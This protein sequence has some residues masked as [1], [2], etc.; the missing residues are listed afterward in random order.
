MAILK[1]YHDNKSHT[2]YESPELFRMDPEKYTPAG[3]F[4]NT[5]EPLLLITELP[6][7]CTVVARNAA[8]DRCFS[9]TKFATT[10]QQSERLPDEAPER[11]LL[12]DL[13][14]TSSRVTR[15]TTD[16]WRTFAITKIPQE[17]GIYLRYEDV[18]KEMCRDQQIEVFSRV[19]RHDLRNQLNIMLGIAESFEAGTNITALR[20][21]IDTLLDIG[22]TL[23]RTTTIS[24]HPHPLPVCDVVERVRHTNA[25]ISVNQCTTD[26]TIDHRVEIALQSM[27]SATDLE[28]EANATLTF[29]CPPDG[30]VL[31]ITLDGTSALF[32]QEDRLA[33]RGEGEHPKSDPPRAAIWLAYWLFTCTGCFLTFSRMDHLVIQV[34]LIE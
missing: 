28:Q 30:D 19:F 11:A 12:T 13:H 27:V 16:G 32:R 23:G 18:T 20:R 25:R 10:L 31:T 2:R 3:L 4:D 9:E 7:V 33:L 6:N 15:R 26:T 14:P 22:G 29:D 5:P 8:F 17:D 34:P 24:D 21:A 1:Y